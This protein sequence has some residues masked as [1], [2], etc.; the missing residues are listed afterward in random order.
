MARVYYPSLNDGEAITVEFVPL[1]GGA[2]ALQLLIDTGFTGKSS[3]ILGQDA[4][5]LIRAEIP[6]AQTAG[7]LQGVQNR[8]WVTCRIP[9]LGCEHTLIAIIADL[10]ALSLPAGI[11]GMA[12]LSFL[13][14]FT[15]WGAEH[16]ANGWRFFLSEEKRRTKK[17]ASK[18]RRA[19]RRKKR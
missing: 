15:R 6:P 11:Q 18:P 7:A 1:D 17:R 12:G 10:A 5:D 19:R 9:E 2:R 16:T 4:I 14:H 13:R 8:A 3:L